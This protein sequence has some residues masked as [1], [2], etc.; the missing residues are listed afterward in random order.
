MKISNVEKDIEVDIGI[1]GILSIIAD[2]FLFLIML[3]VLFK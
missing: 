3:I 2:T 1:I